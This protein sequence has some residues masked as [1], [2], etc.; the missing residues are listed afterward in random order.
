M[1]DAR[2]PLFKRAK[3][4]VRYLLIRAAMAVVSL[5][6]IH[7]ASRL[8]RTLGGLAS[9][10][11]TGERRK[12]LESLGI[13]FPHLTQGERET[14]ATRCF[15]HLGQCA[16]EL[17][18][19]QQLDA[20][21]AEVI[22]WPAADRAVLDAARARQ[23]GVLFISGHVG[24]WEMLARTV[25]LHGYPCQTI[26]KETT[27][28]RTTAMVERFRASGRLKSI[29]RGQP[30]AARAMLKALKHGEILGMLIDQDTD[31]QSVF[32]PFFGRPA[33]TPRAAAD[34]ALRTDA[35]VVLGFCQRVGPMKYRLSFRE[36]QRPDGDDEA[37]VVALTQSL[38][39]GIEEAI[40]SAPEQWVWMHRR[41]KSPAPQLPAANAVQVGN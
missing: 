29:W 8:G 20:S 1:S 40:R 18:C 6:P 9:R 14:L 34:L 7:L 3:R 15:E 22:E 11:V 19:I 12:A 2:P 16:M 21:L 38:S 36:V 31:V 30:G 10:V 5:L 23:K 24:H 32:V 41:W 17:V 25:A 28:P 26:A 27:D 13:A 35:A 39:L 37:A 33:K 4:F